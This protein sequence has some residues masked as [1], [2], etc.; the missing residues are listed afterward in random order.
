MCVF[1]CVCVCVCVCEMS[2][3]D[4]LKI[5]FKTRYKYQESTFWSDIT[6]SYNCKTAFSIK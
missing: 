4:Y 1:E 6:E 3:I 2:A 5:T